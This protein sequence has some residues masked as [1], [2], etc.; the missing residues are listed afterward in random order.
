MGTI[1]TTCRILVVR[2]IMRILVYIAIAA[3]LVGCATRPDPIAQLVT[4]VS[5]EPEWRYG[6]YPTIELSQ[7]A[8]SRQVVEQIFKTTAFH[9]DSGIR[10]VTSF[11]ILQIREA[12]IPANGSDS[13]T[14]ALVETD[15]GR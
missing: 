13:Y 14:T 8:T 11:K 12:N 2:L 4:R 15:F 7:T 1:T 9:T 10:S 5:A 6:I 3:S